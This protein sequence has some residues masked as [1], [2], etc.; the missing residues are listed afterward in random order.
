MNHQTHRDPPLVRTG[1]LHLRRL[2]GDLSQTFPRNSLFVFRAAVREIQLGRNLEEAST[3][4]VL[5]IPLLLHV[6]QQKLR[7]LR[8]LT[9][10]TR[11]AVLAGLRNA[12]L[13]GISPE[14]HTLHTPQTLVASTTVTEAGHTT[15][16][17][18]WNAID[19]LRSIGLGGGDG[20]RLAQGISP[21][22]LQFLRV[23][24]VFF[25]IIAILQT[26]PAISPL[27]S[28]TAWTP[29]I[30]VL[31]ISIIREGIH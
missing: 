17:S 10:I 25:L 22:L 24:N 3:F 4:F 11:E 28:S 27:G 23:A 1:V 26:I 8:N 5:S 15:P 18:L 21:L 16:E 7:N 9:Q 12:G 14:H 31:S 20:G 6:I 29:L 30:I 13:A 19:V 2:V